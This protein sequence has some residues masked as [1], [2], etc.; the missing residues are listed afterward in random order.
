MADSVQ[1]I[2]EMVAH[3]DTLPKTTAGDVKVEDPTELAVSFVGIVAP[4]YGADLDALQ[5]RAEAAESLAAARQIELIGLRADVDNFRS[6]VSQAV[7]A[8]A[9]NNVTAAQ[10]ALA[11]AG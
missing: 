11:T 5:T 4:L 8:L 3:L 6:A 10:A 7:G 2:A 1:M 9:S